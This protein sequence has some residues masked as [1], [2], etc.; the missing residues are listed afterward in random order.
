[1]PSSRVDSLELTGRDERALVA[2]APE[3]SGE[4]LLR[5]NLEAELRVQLQRF[6]G[7]IDAGDETPLP[8][9]S[10]KIADR[11]ALKN[12]LRSA[13]FVDGHNVFQ[14]RKAAPLPSASFCNRR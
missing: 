8:T 1:M 14:T 3:L 5:V 10:F 2:L 7:A 9:C 11:E 4:H 12:Y 6:V 13:M